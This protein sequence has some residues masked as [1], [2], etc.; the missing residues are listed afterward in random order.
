MTVTWGIF[1]P[2][3][4]R[5]VADHIALRI[6]TCTCDGWASQAIHPNVSGEMKWGLITNIEWDLMLASKNQGSLYMDHGCKWRKFWR[7]KWGRQTHICLGNS[8]NCG[9]II[10]G[11][12]V[13]SQLPGQWKTLQQQ[14]AQWAVAR[15]S[16]QPK[17]DSHGLSDASAGAVTLHCQKQVCFH[18]YEIGWSRVK[19]LGT[20]SCMPRFIFD[21][22]WMHC[23][24]REHYC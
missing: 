16:W 10:S 21:T 1:S 8:R 6:F 7:H 19:N 23:F 12:S 9:K 15:R 22:I 18:Y 17:L 3:L 4:S 13:W 2:W 14:L 11:H 24:P 5:W 20:L